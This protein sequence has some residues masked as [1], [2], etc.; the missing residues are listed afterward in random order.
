MTLGN[1]TELPSFVL[2]QLG[3]RRFALPS[4]NVAELAPPV[5]LHA[6]PHRTPMV[7]GVIVRRGRIIPVYDVAPVLIG[8]EAPTKRF[9]LV[10]IRRF[11]NKQEPC[12]IGV[13]G[14]CELRNAEL[15]PPQLG[16]PPYVAGV[17]ALD[18]G[19]VEV[20]D[21]DALVGAG[22]VPAA[23]AEAEVQR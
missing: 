23:A 3:N 22:P 11:G 17:L 9:Y 20:L 12:A 15:W 14:E 10:T 16:Q 5:R 2:L 19:T 18:E 4:E 1:P 6:F 13:T 8:R 7:A 21:L